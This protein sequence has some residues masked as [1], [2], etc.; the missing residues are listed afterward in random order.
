M[1][2]LVTNVRIGEGEAPPDASTAP[3]AVAAHL[4]VPVARVASVELMRRSLDARPRP[5]LWRGNFR[6]ELV[7]GDAD[8]LARKVGGVRPFSARDE[9]RRTGSF[10]IPAGLRWTSRPIVV[11][12]GP[13]GLFAALRLGEAGAP[14]ILLERGQ[15]VEGRVPAVNGFW[16]GRPLD[17]ENNILFGEGGA[18]TF[19]DGKIYTRRRDGELGYVFRALV[20]AGADPE[21][22]QESWAHLGTDKVRAILPAMRERIRASGVEIRFGAAVAAFLVEEGRCV[23]V[24]LASGEEL[25][26]GP[27]IVATGHSARDTMHAL[28][29]AGAAAELR[30]IAIGARIEHPQLVIDAARYPGGRG[31]LPPASYRLADDRENER[32]A[33]TFCMCP[34]GMVVPAQE[35][36]GRVVVN[37]MSFAARRAMWANSALIVQV[38]PEDY[39]GT[40]PLAGVR[41]QDAIEQRAFAVAGGGYAA[42]AQRVSDFLAGRPSVDLPRMS[43]PFGGVPCD[44]AEVLPKPVVEGMRRA[45][46]EFDKEIEGFAGSEGVLIAPETRTTAPLRFLRGADL[47]SPSLAGLLPVGEGAGWAG[48]IV[49][50]ALDGFRA[51]EAVIGAT[52]RG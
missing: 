4:S 35:Q 36:P 26:G 48:G 50:A 34:G 20:D 8:V 10:P 46:L 17:P 12:A 2:L 19:S 9:A 18:G 24:R 45:I 43:Y 15:P 30:P 5:P 39:D 22:L 44:L 13:A 21:I 33:Y 47:Q 37:G 3:A 6:V 27:V 52:G 11:G 28:L 1:A 31:E 14:A 32:A 16:R 38:G 29:D 40:D 41:F 42:P 23:G 51:A 7:G 25:R 49:S